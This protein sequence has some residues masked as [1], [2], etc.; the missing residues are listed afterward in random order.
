[1]R[2]TDHRVTFEGKVFEEPLGLSHH[3]RNLVSGKKV[4]DEEESG[5]MVRDE[6]LDCDGYGV[7]S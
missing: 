2:E 4:G 6:A 1:M 3:L 7:G 5:D